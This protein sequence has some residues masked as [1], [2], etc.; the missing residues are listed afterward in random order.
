MP[1]AAH[2]RDQLEALLAH[3]IP[4]ALSPKPRIIREF[5]PTGIRSIDELLQGGFPASAITEV[6]GRECSG[7]TSLALSLIAG[8]TSVGKVCAWVD[9]SDALYPESVAAAGVDLPRLLWIRCGVGGENNAAPL[10]QPLFS[11]EVSSATIPAKVP[12]KY[13]IARPVT[14]GLHGGGFGPHPRNEVKGLSQAIAGLL[15][16]EKATPWP[17]ELQTTKPEGKNSECDEGSKSSIYK[18]VYAPKKPWSRLDQALRAVDLLLQN[19]GFS[20]IVLDIASIAPEHALRVPL[21]TWFRYRA[22]AEQKQTSLILLLQHP[23][24]KSSAALT[25]RLHASDPRSDGTVFAGVDF[26]AEVERQ[27]FSPNPQNMFTLRKPPQ[28]QRWARWQNHAAWT[29][30]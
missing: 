21:A 17:I 2:L 28:P 18:K 29:G 26:L 16:K 22:V 14:K 19:G 6:V 20:A 24:A 11:S 13:F 5:V 9:V 27:R 30:R 4:G 7:R 8:L 23:C 10:S 3:K 12:G 1:A 15:G 25:L